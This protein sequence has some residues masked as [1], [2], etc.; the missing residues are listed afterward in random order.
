MP[1][2]PPAGP[3]SGSPYGAGSTGPTASPDQRCRIEAPAARWPQGGP[4]GHIGPRPGVRRPGRPGGQPRGRSGALCGDFPGGSPASVGSL[5][6]GE[7]TERLIAPPRDENAPAI[8][9]DLSPV[10]PPPGAPFPLPDRACRRHLTPAR[11]RARQNGRKPCIA[12]PLRQARAA[13]RLFTAL[14]ARPA[15]DRRPGK[16]CHCGK[17]SY[18]PAGNPASTALTRA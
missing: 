18:P 6:A 5:P 17:L 8:G 14:G 2:R 11:V 13:F 7:A 9:A 12:D 1:R 10:R 4:L 3:F 16:V 15:R